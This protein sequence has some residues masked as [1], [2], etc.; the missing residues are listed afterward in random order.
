MA[1][2]LL[3][4]EAKTYLHAGAMPDPITCETKDVCVFFSVGIW[5]RT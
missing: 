4:P 1:M 5:C 3:L 2:R